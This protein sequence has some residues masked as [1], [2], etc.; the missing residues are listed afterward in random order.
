MGRSWRIPD[1]SGGGGMMISRGEHGDVVGREEGGGSVCISRK[2]DLPVLPSAHRVRLSSED[3]RQ[4]VLFSDG[5]N[6]LGMS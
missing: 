2:C 5:Q 4:S 3:T 1:G 6:F